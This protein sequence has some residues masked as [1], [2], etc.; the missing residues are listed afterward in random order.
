VAEPQ[1]IQVIDRSEI[2]ALIDRLEQGELRDGDL[3]RVVELLELVVRLADECASHRVSL[4][5]LQWMMFG[6]RSDK[7]GPSETRT[8]PPASDAMTTDETSTST[9]TDAPAPGPKPRAPGHGRM[10]TER[11][12]GAKIV[13]CDH[14]EIRVGERCPDRPCPGHLYDTNAPSILIERVGQP[15]VS[16]VAYERTVLRCSR[17]QERFRATVP[18][19]HCP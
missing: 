8:S 1:S 7:R 16:A 5:R 15:I 10:K 4:R 13:R 6:P 14:V 12:T 11:Y 3:L 17:C 2:G 18:A 9:T 19:E